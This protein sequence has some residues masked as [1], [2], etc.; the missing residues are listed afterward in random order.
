MK[1]NL[2]VIPRGKDQ[3][4]APGLAIRSLCQLPT[5]NRIRF[6]RKNGYPRFLCRFYSIDPER[7]NFLEDP[8]I[9]SRLYLSSPRSFND[10]FDMRPKAVAD[11]RLTD[12]IGKIERLH[13]PSRKAAHEAKAR[14]KEI[15]RS[16]GQGRLKVRHRAAGAAMVVPVLSGLLP[17]VGQPCCHC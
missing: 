3:A 6:L 7:P 2:L 16:Q 15:W 14:A 1:N 8:L 11:G 5:E 4:I 13:S 17:S 12:L 9:N 10:P